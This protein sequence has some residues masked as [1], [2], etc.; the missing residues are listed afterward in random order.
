MD[1]GNNSALVVEFSREA[2]AALVDCEAAA[3]LGQSRRH[4]VSADF[5]RENRRILDVFGGVIKIELT[6]V[7][8]AS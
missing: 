7:L 8:Q 3:G 2:T 6:S 4:G 5:A 1:P